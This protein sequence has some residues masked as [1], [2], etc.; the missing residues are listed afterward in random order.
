MEPLETI[1]GR[2]SAGEFDESLDALSSMIQIRRRV[3]ATRVLFTVKAGDRVRLKNTRSKYLNGCV[4]TVRRVEG[5]RVVLAL[6]RP[7]GRFGRGDV[8]SPASTV[9]L[10]S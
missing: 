1:F 2:L 10:V 7:V 5:D 9:E 4:G 3:M 8:H 6:D